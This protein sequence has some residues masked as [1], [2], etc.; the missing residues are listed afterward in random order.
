[1]TEGIGRGGIWLTEK[2]G[3]KRNTHTRKKTRF[4]IV[5]C[6][7]LPLFLKKKEIYIFV[8]VCCLYSS[9]MDTSYPTA[10]GAAD[11]PS[12]LPSCVYYSAAL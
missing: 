1:M 7:L 2:K 3:E 10:R 12:H 4:H 9:P 8:T 11:S 6:V 5:P